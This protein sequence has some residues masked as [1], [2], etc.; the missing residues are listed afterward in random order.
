MKLSNDLI[1]NG[2]VAFDSGL[3]QQVLVM[4][5]VLCFLGDSPMHAEITNTLNPGVSLNPCRVCSLQISILAN[6]PSETYVMQCVGLNSLGERVESN[7][8]KWNNINDV[9]ITQ[10]KTRNKEKINKINSL[11]ENGKVDKIFNPFLQL[12]GFDGCNDTRVEVIHVFLLGAI[13]YMIRDFM[14]HLKSKDLPQLIA[15]WE[16]LNK[17]SLDLAELNGKYFVKHFKSLVGKYFKKA[18]Q[19]IPFMFYQFMDSAKRE[20]WS[21]PC[22]LA[23]YVYQTSILNLYDYLKE[24]SQ[25]ID[26]F[27]H[28]VIK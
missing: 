23:P 15:F 28:H 27:L 25:K 16:S 24:C 7:L 4:T 17:E 21:L 18:I 9:F 10:W 14:I 1:T 2:L 12:K 22:H 8:R 5:A 3:N 20:L 11:I 26:I 6:K 13:K 19:M